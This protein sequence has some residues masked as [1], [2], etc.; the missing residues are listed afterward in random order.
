MRATGTERIHRMNDGKSIAS[1]K[2]FR[3]SASLLLCANMFL[4]FTVY[5]LLKTA[6]ESLI[7]T[8]VGAEWKSYSGLVQALI[9]LA[10]MPAYGAL[11][12][13][14]NR[15][16]L[17]SGIALLFAGNL[18]VFAAL[19]RAGIRIGMV[20]YVWL[21]LFSVVAVTQVWVFANDLYSEQQGNRIFPILGLAGSLGALAGAE[22][23][24]PLF[25]L[26]P[27]WKIMLA[28]GLVLV[29]SALLTHATDRR[30]R[31]SSLA[32]CAIAE[33]SIGGDGCFHVVLNSRYLTLIAMLVIV[34]NMANGIGEFV[35]SKMAIR[36]AQQACA[37]GSTASQRQL[38]GMFYASYFAVGNLTGLLLQGVV[39]SRAIRRLGAARSL[40]LGPAITAVGYAALAW[41]PG[42]GLARG[43]KIAENSVDYTLGKTALNSL[44]LRTSRVAKYKGKTVIDTL[45][46]R[47][48]D[49]LQAV[50]VFGGTGMA[51][52][53]RDYAI[54]NILLAA[55]A[56]FMIL[57]IDREH[58]RLAAVPSP[59]EMPGRRELVT[60]D[61]SCALNTAALARTAGE[62]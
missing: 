43:V 61:L 6:R 28:A 10:A 45:F 34:V 47:V 51:L 55:A 20:F 29:I 41:L 21:G 62:A 19:D 22:L 37:H 40:L 7:L 56:A 13:R 42:A 59:K 31:R 24:K 38:I 3:V 57:Q 18:F 5:Y 9:L 16:R 17:M 33:K 1:E 46:Y 30:A 49:L 23:A 26:I 36:F 8:Q 48:G 52:D 35:L 15:V 53:I 11:A 2:K 25:G 58:R 14:W 50:V 32:Q 27:I 39:V 54:L 60:A 44:F 4:L 12:S